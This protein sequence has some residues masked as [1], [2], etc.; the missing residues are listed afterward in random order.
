MHRNK[1][2][3]EVSPRVLKMP[4]RFGG[5]TPRGI[6]LLLAVRFTPMAQGVPHEH[7]TAG[8]AM[9]STGLLELFSKATVYYSA[10]R[11]GHSCACDRIVYTKGLRAGP[12]MYN[13]ICK[14]SATKSVKGPLTSTST[15]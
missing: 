10:S 9:P 4:R 13:Y 15:C 6:G 8:E 7:C 1:G 2:Y 12:C 14:T 5:D 11:D 3:E